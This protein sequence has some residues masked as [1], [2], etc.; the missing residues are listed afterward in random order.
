MLG[1]GDGAEAQPL[2]CLHHLGEAV[3]A[4][5]LRGVATLADGVLD[6]EL[7]VD[8]L[9][10]QMT[11]P[12][13]WPKDDGSVSMKSSLKSYLSGRLFVRS[14]TSPYGAC[15]P[16]IDLVALEEHADVQPVGPAA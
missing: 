2:G 4:Q 16:D 13:I 14:R 1:E 12:T 6:G 9:N 11:V 10:N 8:S 3:R 5:Q 7:H 15:M